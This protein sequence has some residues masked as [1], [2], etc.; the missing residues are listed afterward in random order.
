MEY[1]GSL[2]RKKQIKL[3]LKQNTLSFFLSAHDQDR[4]ACKNSNLPVVQKKVIQSINDWQISVH[5]LDTY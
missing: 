5:L 4:N 1:H 3:L 2:K